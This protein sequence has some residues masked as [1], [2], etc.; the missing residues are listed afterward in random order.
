[1]IT[2]PSHSVNLSATLTGLQLVPIYDYS[3]NLRNVRVVAMS[4]DAPAPSWAQP[5]RR[6]P[7]PQEMATINAVAPLPGEAVVPTWLER[8]ASTYLTA[9]YG[10]LITP[11]TPPAT[12]PTKK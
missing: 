5:N 2:I 9:V 12:G 10:D 4:G 3:G 6:M 1:M 11:P 7:T 8:A